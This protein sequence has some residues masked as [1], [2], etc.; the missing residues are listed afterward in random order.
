ML[1]VNDIN[2]N[3]LNQ[4]ELIKIIDD[5]SAEAERANKKSQRE[6]V[7]LHR[8][9]DQEKMIANAK[10]NQRVTHNLAQQERD[11]YL[12]LL[13][14]N[15]TN[16]IL[17]LDRMDRIVY[18]TDGFI[19]AIHY[20]TDSEVSGKTYQEIFSTF[21]D[22]SLIDNIAETIQNAARQKNTLI[23]EDTI[24]ISGNG[25]SRKYLIHISPML[26]S[27]NVLEGSMLLFHDV[28]DIERARGEAEKA[29]RAKGDFLAN[30]SHEMRTP[31]N[32]IIGMS[33]I[34]RVADTIERKDYCLDRIEDA[35][36]HLL[37]IINDILD[38]SK[39]EASKFE[40]SDVYFSFENI[41]QRVSTVVSFKTDEK[42]Q[43]FCVNADANIP[44]ILKGDDQR[45]TQVITNLVTNAVK[46]TPENGTIN[47]DAHLISED[48]NIC[49]IQVDIRDTGIG[50]SEE[51]IKR[52]FNSFEQAD[53]STS[54]RFG[55]T[56][57]GLAISKNIVEIM[58][59]EI[60]VEST[61][62][63]GSTFSFTVKLEAVDS[64]NL[65]EDTLKK[66]GAGSTFVQ[67]FDSIKGIFAGYRLL[68]AE[69]IDI[70]REIVISLLEPTSIDIDCAVNGKEAFE[71][72]MDDPK[73]YDL[74]FMD[75]QMPE[76]DGYETTRLIRSQDFLKAKEIPIIAMTANVFKEDIERCIAA[77]MNDHIGKPINISE[78][79]EVLRKYLLY[80][81]DE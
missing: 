15:S 57:L 5:I 76:L 9:I 40:L 56:G 78:V 2:L 19:K 44:S 37:G 11:K 12:R 42:H 46:F 31:M 6:I 58:G 18:C 67:D 26:N 16:I 3:T 79:V 69:D 39:I 21:A 45:L 23:V 20:A 4:S 27:Q 32:A 66:L 14:G 81:M 60:W 17:L 70:N 1:D 13:L 72:F 63:V 62:D 47:L 64:S 77:G 73:K 25:D 24:D 7:H 22:R 71:L 41:L 49:T 65:D 38:M 55:G 35:S 8:A 28:S 52:L 34:G 10:A 36:K 30:M 53:S 74:I 59:G 51:Q 68:L 75:V 61:P 43:A 48:Y 33:T 29:S 50:I 80:Y 54:R